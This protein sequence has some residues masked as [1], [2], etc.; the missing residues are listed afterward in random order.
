MPSPLVQHMADIIVSEL[1]HPT[2]PWLREFPPVTKLA[3]IF[4]LD[5]IV[6]DR[7]LAF[8]GRDVLRALLAPAKPPTLLTPTNHPANRAAAHR[9]I[10]HRPDER[11]IAN[12]LIR[13]L[14]SGWYRYTSLDGTSCTRP[15]P[16]VHEICLQF[17]CGPTAARLALEHLALHNLL[18]APTPTGSIPPP[19]PLGARKG[20]TT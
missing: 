2:S 4:H 6:I 20:A 16:T 18:P 19:T 13:R 14:N 12:E 7:A 17:A 15:F 5:P 8:I 11:A 1:T 10:R 9:P 3:E